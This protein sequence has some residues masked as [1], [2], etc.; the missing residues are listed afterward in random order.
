MPKPRGRPKKDIPTQQIAIRLPQPLLDRIKAY[1]DRL[2]QSMQ[3]INITR[4]DAIRVLIERGLNSVTHD[5]KPEPA[6]TRTSP[7]R[8]QQRAQ[9]TQ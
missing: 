5:L 2:A 1:T 7:E 8:E 4:A 6:T 9:A 3:G